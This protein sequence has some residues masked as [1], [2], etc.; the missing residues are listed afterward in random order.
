MGNYDKV[1]QYNL[2]QSFVPFVVLKTVFSKLLE[3]FWEIIH[4]RESDFSNVAVA[5][6]LKSLFLIDTF[7]GIHK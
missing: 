2:F 6:L 7:L 4:Y 3:D 1:R 5:T